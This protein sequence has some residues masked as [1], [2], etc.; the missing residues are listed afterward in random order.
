MHVESVNENPYVTVPRKVFTK[1]VGTWKNYTQSMID[2]NPLWANDHEAKK[3]RMLDKYR[4]S[5]DK[6][7]E[8]PMEERNEA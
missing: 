2:V 8:P 4:D 1:Q 3:L 6:G 7:E 5:I